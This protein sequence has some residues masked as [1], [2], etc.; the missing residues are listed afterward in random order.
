MNKKQEE[1]QFVDRVMKRVEIKRLQRT[2]PV[3][4]DPKKVEERVEQLRAE[5]GDR[6]T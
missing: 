1:R 3:L 4:A 6:V 5:L 2:P